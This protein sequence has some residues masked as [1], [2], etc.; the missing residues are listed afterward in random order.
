M[1]E[2]ESAIDWSDVD[3]ETARQILHQGEVFLSAQLTAALAADQRAMTSAS[4]FIGFAAVM[5]GASLAY[6]GEHKDVALF[7]AGLTGAVLMF[8]ASVCCFLAARPR[9]FYYPGNHPNRWWNVCTERL[10]VL[11][12]GETEN[13]QE[14]IDANAGVIASNNKWLGRGIKAAVVAPILAFIVWLL[15]FLQVGASPV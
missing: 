11:T 2:N 6:W 4:I 8:S 7:V 9:D 13:Y 15:L 14:V 10:A 12:A 5:L 3:L 1:D